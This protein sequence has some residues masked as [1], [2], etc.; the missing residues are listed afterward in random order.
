MKKILKYKVSVDTFYNK[1]VYL[2]QIIYITIHFLLSLGVWL[3]L[4]FLVAW[5]QY[6]PI[7]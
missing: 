5:V 7:S 6:S 3:K 2:H 4:V 1:S